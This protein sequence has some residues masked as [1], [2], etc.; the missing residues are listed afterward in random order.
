MAAVLINS[1]RPLDLLDADLRCSNLCLATYTT[2][3]HR[4]VNQ[5]LYASTQRQQALL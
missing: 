1:N 5:G 2:D 4:Q 3:W